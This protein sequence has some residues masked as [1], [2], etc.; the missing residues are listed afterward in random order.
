MTVL[1]LFQTAEHAAECMYPETR[2]QA[3]STHYQLEIS[4]DS[5]SHSTSNPFYETRK[6]LTTYLLLSITLKK[7]PSHCH[8]RRQLQSLKLC[9]CTMSTSGE[10]MKHLRQQH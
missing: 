9:N 5:M 3:Y 10:S 7:G 2:P 4:A 1:P 6:A 8:A